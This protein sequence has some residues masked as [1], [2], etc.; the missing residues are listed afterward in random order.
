MINI[1]DNPLVRELVAR[2]T[3]AP[4]TDATTADANSV[5]EAP[6]SAPAYPAKSLSLVN[7]RYRVD[8]EK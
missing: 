4:G 5:A 2:A 1:A 8:I 6:Q 3:E 7:G